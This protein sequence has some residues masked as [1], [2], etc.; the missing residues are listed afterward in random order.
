MY[1][2]SERALVAVV[3]ALS[4]SPRYEE[5]LSSKRLLFRL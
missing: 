5:A 4:H 2:A 1:G 3:G